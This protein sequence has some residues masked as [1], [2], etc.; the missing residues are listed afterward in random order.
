MFKKEITLNNNFVNNFY[1][2]SIYDLVFIDL[3]F[4]PDFAQVQQVQRIFGYTITR[5]LKT[6]SHQYIKIQF[7]ESKAE[8]KQLIK[9]ILTDLHILQTKIFIGYN[10]VNSDIYC[11]KKRLRSM[12]MRS[13]IKLTTIDL[14]NHPQKEMYRG[15]LNGLF[16][17]L[18][19][20]VNKQINGLYFRKNARKVLAK[21]ENYQ[22]ILST[23]YDYCLEDARNYFYIV[24]NWQS[25]FAEINKENFLQI[26]L[27]K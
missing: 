21:K 11:L 27:Y 6:N 1:N 12:K 20:Q 10:L 24:S 19:I 2:G 18:E 7:L 22:Q 17:Y 9:D 14:V 16:E 4:W 8:E 23:M 15:G 26:P 25:K 3:E 13:E 5:L